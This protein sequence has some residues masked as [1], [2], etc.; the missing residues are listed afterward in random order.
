[1][2]INNIKAFLKKYDIPYF[3]EKTTLIPYFDFNANRATC[4]ALTEKRDLLDKYLI[5]NDISYNVFTCDF[6][7]Y[8]SI[9]CNGKK[10]INTIPRN[11]DDYYS[12]F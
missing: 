1:M 2:K 6:A 11:D 7:N 12:V 3:I 5:N 4:K 10:V 8:Y 9:Y